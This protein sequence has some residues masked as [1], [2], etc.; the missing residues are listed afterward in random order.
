[1]RV[2]ILIYSF[3]TFIV[4]A[5]QEGEKSVRVLELEGLRLSINSAGIGYDVVD[6]NKL[7]SG[8]GLSYIVALSVTNTGSMPISFTDT[9][10]ALFD[11]DGETMPAKTYS[12]TSVGVIND[13]ALNTTVEPGKTEE[14]ML[15]YG[16]KKHGVYRFQFISP[17]DGKRSIADLPA[18]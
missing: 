3:L 11:K 18:S 13:A 10:F 2:C 17:S 1:M 4:M 8:N 15:M 7:D 14:I 6:N 9:S 5:C 12:K 16:V